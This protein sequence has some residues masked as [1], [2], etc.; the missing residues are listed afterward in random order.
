MIIVVIIPRGPGRTAPWASGSTAAT[1]GTQGGTPCLTIVVSSTR[2]CSRVANN[3]A[4]LISR[5]V[6]GLPKKTN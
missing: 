2:F 5:T 3:V 4:D 1:C 6:Q